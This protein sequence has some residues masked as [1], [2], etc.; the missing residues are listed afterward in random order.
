MCVVLVFTIISSAFVYALANSFVARETENASVSTAASSIAD[1]SASNS[2]AVK[3]GVQGSSVCAVSTPNAPGGPD[4]WGGCWPGAYNTGYPQGLPGD[5]RTPVTL[6]NYTGPQEI[7]NCGVTIENKITSWLYIRAGNGTHSPDTPC[8][9]IKNSLVRG[10]IFSDDF[11]AGPVVIMDTEVDLDGD[12]PYIENIGRYNYF[13]YRVNSHGGQGVI[14]CAAYCET[15]DSWIHSMTVGGAY[16]Y[17]A[18]GGNGM[19]EGSWIIDHNWASCGDWES[20]LPN[21]DNDAGCSAVIGFYG[22]FSPIRNI[23]INRNFLKSTFDMSPSGEFRQA[24]YCINPGYYVGKPYPNP[25]NMTITDNIFAR[26][27]SGVCGVFGPS[28]SLNAIGQGAS[29]V[30][31][32][33]RYEDGTIIPRVEE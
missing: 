1:A 23:T 6:T 17:N 19:E 5:T 21:I 9:T 16:H 11:N 26:G 29:N 31:S 13:T 27:G 4:P 14:K 18:I 22:D 10:S 12:L 7:T 15:K 2:G 28:N 8:V 24:G 20:V 32:N 30:W 3:F 33:N 25:T